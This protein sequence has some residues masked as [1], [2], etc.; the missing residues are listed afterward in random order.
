MTINNN[1]KSR[2][3][4]LNFIHLLYFSLSGLDLKFL[5][6]VTGAY[7]ESGLYHTIQSGPLRYTGD[8]KKGEEL[9]IVLNVNLT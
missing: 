6:I 7:Y 4:R 2:P 8:K 3:E 9:A 1:F 5:F